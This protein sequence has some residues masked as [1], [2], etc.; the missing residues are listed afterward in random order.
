MKIL[1]AQDLHISPKWLEESKGHIKRICEVA[2]SEKVDAIT[3]AGD[4]FDRPL[5]ATD[6]NSYDD[7][8]QMGRDLQE[9]APVFFISGT[10]GHDAPGSYAAF[11]DIGWKEINIGKHHVIGDLLIIGIPEITPAFLISQYP[12]LSKQ[13]INEKQYDLVNEIIDKYYAPLA[14]SHSGTVHFMGHGHIAG[15]KFRDDQKPRSTD[16]MYSEEMLNRIGAD[17][18]QFGHLHLL[19]KYYGGS[20]HMTWGDIGFKPGFNIIDTV[21]K[22]SKRFDY[23][24]LERQKYIIK[25]VSDIEIM[26]QS[27]MADTNVWIDIHCNKEFSDGFDCDQSLSEL[28]EAVNIGPLSKITCSIQHTENIRVDIEEYEA[29]KTL[30]DLY[31]IYDPEVP[32]SILL[33]VAESE[34]E[35]GGETEHITPHNFEFL[36]LYLKGSKAGLENGVEEIKIDFN[37]FVT[38]ANLIIGENG[39]GKSFNMGFCTPFSIHLPTGIDLKSL[40]E[41]KD[42]QI[43][44][45]FRDGKD[46]I[47]QKILIDPTLTAPTAKYYMD[48]NGKAIDTVTGTKAPFDDAVNEIFGSIKM[49]MTCA[50]RGQKENNNYPSLENAK[51]TDL[52]KIFTEFAGMDRS[53]LKNYAHEKVGVLKKEIELD[54]REIETLESIE[55][56]KKEIEILIEEKDVLKSDNKLSLERSN[57]TLRH[58]KSDLS[59]YEK[60]I[61]G[62]KSIQDQVDFITAESTNLTADVSVL[63]YK[64]PKINST[65][66]NADSNKAELKKLLDQQTKLNIASGAYFKAQGEFNNQVE[67][68]Q[69]KKTVIDENLEVIK[70]E[71]NEI[72]TLI[73]E[74]KHKLSENEGLINVKESVVTSAND[75]CEFCKKISTSAQKKIDIMLSEIKVCKEIILGKKS[76]IEE[77]ELNLDKQREKY[78]KL[79]ES[80]SKKPEIPQSL[81]DL[82]SEMDNL[83]VDTH[84][85]SE[86]QMIIDGLKTLETKKIDLETSISQKKTRLSEISKQIEIL[87]NK[88][89]DIDITAYNNLRS[90][91]YEIETEISSTSTGI[92]RLTAEI[93][94]LKDRLNKNVQREEKIKTLTEKTS[95]SRNNIS[96]WESIEKAFSPKGIE[97][98]ELSLVAPVINQEANDFLST[99]QPRYSVEIITQDFDSKNN[100]AEKFKI[101]VHDNRASDVKSISVVSGGQAVWSTSALREAI[102]TSVIKRTGRNY[103]YG[104]I[105]EQDGALDNNV[106]ADFY[107]MINSHLAGKKKLISVS[108]NTEAISTIANVIEV[109]DFFV[110]GE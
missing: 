73:D 49:F 3:I 57:E 45:R 18:I 34:R 64:L 36:D 93:E 44:R 38:G 39:T 33:K 86:L 72:K 71:A 63:E 90:R 101:L 85:L 59:I 23:G 20:A 29:C 68:W 95:I 78:K 62:N 9:S 83:K 41:L 67:E 15:M 102:N 24:E 58:F 35:T 94:A 28:K 81:I 99:Y 53:E 65:L 91:I 25:D 2:K 17:Y 11:K 5:M 48:I 8:L 27:V 98:L 60:D 4:F 54:T 50:F 55:E 105:D 26:K 79:Q 108:H 109:T 80:I 70:V 46:I 52:R 13:E 30:E 37:D 22:E 21:T 1:K 100:L 97:A 66:E 92:G 89:K 87:R 104:I 69:N 77:C 16:F 74:S 61:N 107:S 82:K 51:E 12:D 76:R 10:P 32:E 84:K 110:K 31:K 14:K 96:E 19:Q 106:V 40:F 6:K 88:K 7:I 42:S 56:S 103:M 47:T 75:P 43:L